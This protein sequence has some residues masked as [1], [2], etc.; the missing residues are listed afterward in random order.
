MG[1]PMS[2]RLSLKMVFKR[3]NTRHSNFEYL[4]FF[5]F[6]GFSTSAN[7]RKMEAIFSVK[8]A[9]IERRTRP[10]GRLQMSGATGGKKSQRRLSVFLTRKRTVNSNSSTHKEYTEEE[11]S[12]G[13]PV[14]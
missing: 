12:A 1:T 3:H 11:N 4:R 9:L 10:I 8:M 13:G 14:F 7:K 6:V 2:L 5:S